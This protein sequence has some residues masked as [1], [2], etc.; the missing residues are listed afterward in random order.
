[1]SPIGEGLTTGPPAAPSTG[2]SAD[3]RIAA[4]AL[5]YS[6][7]RH[8]LP[9]LRTS[10]PMGSSP[11]VDR[12]STSPSGNRRI[13]IGV[14]GIQTRYPDR[15]T[16]HALLARVC[17]SVIVGRRSRSGPRRSVL[18]VCLVVPRLAQSLLGL[19]RMLRVV[20][21]VSVFGR[22]CHR[23][24][25]APSNGPANARASASEEGLPSGPGYGPDRCRC[26]PLLESCGAESLATRHP[27]TGKRVG[28]HSREARTGATWI[29][30]H[31][32][33]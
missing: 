23:D 7:T 24:A 18:L 3:S 15:Y 19:Q 28:A 26:L 2:G 6:R 10:A 17:R 11:R 5:S 8:R 16:G 27:E 22:F 20:V 32:H 25:S 31:Q 29:P 1:M 12:C 4:P 13:R 33:A 14:V 9:R 30:V 21:T